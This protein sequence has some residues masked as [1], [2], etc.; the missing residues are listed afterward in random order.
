MQL[1]HYAMCLIIVS[2]NKRAGS[3]YVVIDERQATRV[4]VIQ[5]NWLWPVSQRKRPSIQYLHA[6]EADARSSH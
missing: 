6:Y 4:H 3:G 2:L 5:L 1:S